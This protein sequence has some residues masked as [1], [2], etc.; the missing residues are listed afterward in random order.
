MPIYK[1]LKQHKLLLDTHVWFWLMV[2]DEKLAN[3]LKTQLKGASKMI[4]F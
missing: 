1:K 3:H 2:G 4:L